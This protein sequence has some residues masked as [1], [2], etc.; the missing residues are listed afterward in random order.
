MALFCLLAG[1]VKGR[2][3]GLLLTVWRVDELQRAG[4]EVVGALHRKFWRLWGMFSQRLR[5][6]FVFQ[7]FFRIHVT[8]SRSTPAQQQRAMMIAASIPQRII[9]NHDVQARPGA[10]NR[11]SRPPNQALRAHYTCQAPETGLSWAHEIERLRSAVRQV[12][13]SAQLATTPTPQ[14]LT[15]QSIAPTTFITPNNSITMQAK[16]LLISALA[17]VATAQDIGAALDNLGSAAGDVATVAGGDLTS[18]AANLGGD[19]TSK[20]AAAGSDITSAAGAIA[21]GASSLASAAKSAATGAV[22][23]SSLKSEASGLKSDVSSALA[24]ATAGAAGIFSDINSKY[25]SVKGWNTFASDVSSIGLTN[26]ESLFG[27]L[28]TQTAIPKS[29]AASVTSD[30]MAAAATATGGSASGSAAQASATGAAN[31]NGV[32][33]G[34]IMAAAAGVAGFFVL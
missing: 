18:K 10:Q 25:S 4:R 8:E 24:S 34:G 9:I 5:R 30:F 26:T 19:I 22:D 32:A 31:A 21:T 20:A 3:G 6:V 13:S 17:A 29:A 7:K 14:P 33:L 11:P 1:A 2:A 15:H 28:M 23:V 27:Y 16:F 12:W